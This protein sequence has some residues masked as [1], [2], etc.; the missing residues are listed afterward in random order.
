VSFVDG[1]NLHGQIGVVGVAFVVVPVVVI[2]C[3][4][5]LKMREIATK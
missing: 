3:L 4:L 1:R 5:C 2:H